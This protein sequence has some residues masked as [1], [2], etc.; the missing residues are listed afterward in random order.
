MQTAQK[1]HPSKTSSHIPSHVEGDDETALMQQV[2][3]QDPQAFETLYYRHIP[4]LRG[5]VM[6][7]APQPEI[8][9]EVLNDV[10]MVFW[11]NTARIPPDAA[12]AAW[13]HGIARKKLLRAWHRASHGKTPPLYA[14]ADVSETTPE[15]D[16]LYREQ[17]SCLTRYVSK[18]PPEQRMIA[19]L[20]L[21]Q[22]CS[23]EEISR[24]TETNVN[25]VK[26]RL[27]RIRHRLSEALAGER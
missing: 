19:E 25:T 14:T 22:E 5:Y 21:Y 3:Q 12:L 26:S 27:S 16:L 23:L 10:M 8:V 13:L 1:Q 6:R 9:D 17:K 15:N 4:R 11:Q 20:W 7:H 18:L 24:R 2:L